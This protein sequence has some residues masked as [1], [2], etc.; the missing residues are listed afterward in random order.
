M[1]AAKY[2]YLQKMGAQ[3]GLACATGDFVNRF[4]NNFYSVNYE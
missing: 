1:Y 2:L 4:I 3:T